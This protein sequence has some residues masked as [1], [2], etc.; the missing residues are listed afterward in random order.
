MTNEGA[1]GAGAVVDYA[2]LSR[3]DAIHRGNLIVKRTAA[4]VVLLGLAV[5]VVLAAAGCPKSGEGKVE[6]PPTPPT[7]A[8]T[9]P[10]AETAAT[11]PPGNIGNAKNA[12]GKYICPVLGDPVT[13]FSKENSSE[14]EGKA[15]FYC[16]PGCKEKFDADPAKYA[17]AAAAGKAPEGSEP[18]EASGEQTEG[19]GGTR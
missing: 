18:S 8:Q 6:T 14:Y 1:G 17:K 13:D 3:G 4:V 12:E 16:C 10:S 5:L 7:T 19:S 11:Q 15:Y 2:G 9:T